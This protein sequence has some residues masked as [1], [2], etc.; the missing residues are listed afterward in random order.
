MSRQC[1]LVALLCAVLLPGIAAAAEKVAV[2]N[3]ELIDTS[4]DG[5]M[6]G[7]NAAEQLRL[8]GMAPRLREW[9]GR[10]AKYDVADMAPVETRAEASNLE[11]CG[12]CVARLA[13]EVGAEIAVTG[14]VQ[15]VSNLILNVNLYV[16]DV[17]SKKAVAAMSTDIRSNSDESWHRGLAWLIA[18]RLP[19]ALEKVA[20]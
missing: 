11:A 15:K 1:A 12:G 20:R 9:F 16:T 14:T 19:A 18:H 13:H 7:P 2:F 3:F 5:Q 10:Q 6:L 17:E 4:L 8:A